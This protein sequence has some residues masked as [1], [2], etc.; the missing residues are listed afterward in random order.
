MTDSNR[1]RIPPVYRDRVLERGRAKYVLG[2]L[3]RIFIYFRYE[4][5]RGYARFRGAR[6]GKNSIISWRLALRANPKLT[7][8]EDSVIEA[9]DLDLRGEIIIADHVIINR[10]VSIIRV[11]HRIDDDTRY[12]TRYYPPLKIESYSWL[13]T[14]CKIL[15]SVTEIASG[16]V[17]G[18]Y[19]VLAKNT[20]SNG[21]YAGNPAIL[22]RLHNTIFNDLVVCSLMGGDLKYYL[23]AK[24]GGNAVSE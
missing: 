23:Q 19:S 15:P 1:L 6:I 14:G 2:L 12:G 16:T 10:E 18:A 17:V 20:R 7:V 8:G 22:K 24:S 21:V 4:I 3:S 5:I 11:S 13:A 9:D